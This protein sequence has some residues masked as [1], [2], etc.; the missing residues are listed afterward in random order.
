MSPKKQSRIFIAAFFIT[1]KCD[2]L[3][4]EEDALNFKRTRRDKTL[5]ANCKVSEAFDVKEL[6]AFD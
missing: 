6:F 5:I 2:L 1:P 4:R 3:S